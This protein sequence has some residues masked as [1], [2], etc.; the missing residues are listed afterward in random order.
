[1]GRD[2]IIYNDSGGAII[3][4]MGIP[5]D[6]VR[7]YRWTYGRSHDRALWVPLKGPFAYPLPDAKSV[8][9]PSPGVFKQPYGR[10]LCL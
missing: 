8:L 4:R 3:A 7:S 1:M 9:M 2:N 5:L 6:S 10:G